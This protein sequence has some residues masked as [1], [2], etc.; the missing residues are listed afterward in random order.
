MLHRDLAT[1]DVAVDHIARDHVRA[2]RSGQ[3]SDA[4]ALAGRITSTV[5]ERRSL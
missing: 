3:L 5:T 4:E 2:R 1:T